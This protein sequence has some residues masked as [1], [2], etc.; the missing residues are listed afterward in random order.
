[1]KKLID[2]AFVYA[3]AAMAGGVF[4][5]EFTRLN[6]FDGRTA[7][8]FVHTHLFMLGMFFFLIVAIL[9]GR[10]ALRAQRRFGLFFLLYNA[11]VTITAATLLWRGVLQVLGG[12]VS[13]VLSASIS[14]IAGAGH[15]MTGVG[16]VLF[17]LIARSCCNDR[18]GKSV[19]ASVRNF[20]SRL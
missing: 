1:M 17:F 20:P 3:C 5:R 12:E 8:G 4:Y 13:K 10:L 16:L 9:D 14:G 7:L 2:T 6:G 18:L 15:I 11:G 19:H